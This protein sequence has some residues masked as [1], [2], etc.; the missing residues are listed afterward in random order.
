MLMNTFVVKHKNCWYFCWP[1]NATM[2]SYDCDYMI[3]TY[4]STYI[5]AYI[6]LYIL[7]ANF[8]NWSGISRKCL[9]THCQIHR[10]ILLSLYFLGTGKTYTGTKLVYLFDK[11][12]LKMQE[13]GHER[14]QLVF[15]GP[16]NKS[17]DLVASKY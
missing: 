4:I 9:N 10:R 5:L 11:I 1:R 7:L 6:R 12:N 2:F 15:C 17:V 13:Q 3:S 16:N 14:M 8:Q